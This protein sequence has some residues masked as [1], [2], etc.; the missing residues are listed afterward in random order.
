MSTALY[1]S[2]L[3]IYRKTL[4]R[5]GAVH[6]LAYRFTERAVVSAL[7][8]GLGFRTAKDDPLSFRLD[9]LL[10]RYEA[11]TA[12]VFKSLLR[13][14]MTVVDVGAHIGYYTRIFAQRV[15]PRG[16]VIA[17]EPHPLTFKILAGNLASCANV[18]LVHEAASDRTGTAMLYDSNPDVGSSSLRLDESKREYYTQRLVGTEIAPRAVA[19]LPTSTY[20]VKTRT[21]DASL[22]LAGIDRVD[23]VKMD[24]EGA[25]LAALRGMKET[26]RRSASV[27]LVVELNPRSLESF[28]ITPASF[29]EQLTESGFR[30]IEPIE[31]GGGAKF[32]ARSSFAQW[33]EQFS[34]NYRRVN[35]LC[36]K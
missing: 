20:S 13:P 5:S 21:L 28:G 8:S 30:S 14:G 29:F 23:V 24:I 19:G 3:G 9:L 27:S 7:E 10:G 36:R 2:A 32:E 18:I 11:E 6:A 12:A 26:L 34:A 25:E 15:G 17:F 16:R 33:A 35:L 31:D 22:S 4:K 1:S